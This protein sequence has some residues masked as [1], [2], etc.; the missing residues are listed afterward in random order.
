MNDKFTLTCIGTN[1]KHTRFN[2]FDMTGANCG[3]ICIQTKDIIPFI[4]RAWA[5]NVQW[6]GW[7]P[8]PLKPSQ[9]EPSAQDAHG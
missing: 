2:L 1:P 9:S 3:T 5:D 4:A 8:E 6:Q 7:V